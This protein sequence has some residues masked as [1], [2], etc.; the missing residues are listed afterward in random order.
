VEPPWCPFNRIQVGSLLADVE[1]RCSPLQRLT[2][3]A[4]AEAQPLAHSLIHGS[5][6]DNGGV[7]HRATWDNAMNYPQN[8]AER[9]TVFRR[10]NGTPLMKS[11]IQLA[12]RREVPVAGLPDV[13]P[14]E[15][16]HHS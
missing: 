7:E 4:W 15:L 14:R 8:Y 5:T 9:R 12:L 13:A 1:L 16:V 10:E 11:K 6:G 2:V 3:D